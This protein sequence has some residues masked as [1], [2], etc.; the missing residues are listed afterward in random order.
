MP[1][2][3][4]SVILPPPI[5]RMPP[6]GAV[7]CANLRVGA[8]TFGRRRRGA[9]ATVA[10]AAG[11]DRDR[12]NA[13]HRDRRIWPDES[14][15][16]PPR[17]SQSRPEE[18]TAVSTRPRDVDR[19]RPRAPSP[20]RRRAS[21]AAAAMSRLVARGA[22]ASPP[23]RRR[24]AAAARSGVW[25]VECSTFYAGTRQRGANIKVAR[26]MDPAS[27]YFTPMFV[28]EFGGVPVD[29]FFQRTARAPMDSSGSRGRAL[30][31]TT[32]TW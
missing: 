6:S 18:I 23:R 15:A 17:A 12:R 11:R 20:R 14:A 24:V 9:T 4:A 31:D 21:D 8:S 2:T 10:K 26:P 28:N 5:A 30:L 13:G 16:V 1:N 27:P 29:F 3:S 25:S 32:G 19:V 7:R 22:Y